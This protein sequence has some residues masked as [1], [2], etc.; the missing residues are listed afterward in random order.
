[1]FHL[2]AHFSSIVGM[3]HARRLRIDLCELC[4]NARVAQSRVAQGHVHIGA[5]LLRFLK[6][7]EHVVIAGLG[8]MLAFEVDDVWGD[9]R[10][11]E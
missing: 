8:G 2:P 4:I 5:F 7:V 9:L 1:M 3:N 6:D 11:V 10:V